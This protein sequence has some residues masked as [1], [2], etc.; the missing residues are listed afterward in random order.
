MGS[1]ASGVLLVTGRDEG[2]SWAESEGK[3]EEEES[4]LTCGSKKGRLSVERGLELG[5]I[6]E[7][8]LMLAHR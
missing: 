6:Q 1:T 8:G 2:D 7:E 4:P 3:R 5:Q